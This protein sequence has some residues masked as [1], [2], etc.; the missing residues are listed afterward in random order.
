[1]WSGYA[2]IIGSGS[3][4]ISAHLRIGAELLLNPQ[5]LPYQSTC[6]AFRGHQ[7]HNSNHYQGDRKDETHYRQ[8]NQ[9]DNKQNNGNY[10]KQ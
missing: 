9:A 7:H 2:R 10:Q 3:I 6:L 4:G 1:M 8:H 5:T